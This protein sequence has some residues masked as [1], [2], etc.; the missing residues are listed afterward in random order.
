MDSARDGGIVE[1][2]TDHG[3]TWTSVFNSPYVYNFYGYQTTNVDTIGD[4]ELAFTNTDSTWRDI[5]LCFDISWMTTLPDT[6][7]FRFTFKSDSVD[8]GREGWMIDNIIA[9]Q[10]AIHTII[11]VKQSEYLKVYPNPTSNIVYIEAQKQQEFH[12]IEHMELI[13]AQGEVVA[14]WDNLP[15]KFWFDAG[16]YGN[17]VYLLKI[18]TNLRTETF[19]IVVKK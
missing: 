11:N 7:M 14:K 15:T 12:I 17:G 3:S 1:Y 4:G 5:W 19:S 18:K 16:K 6:L 13:N 8:H 10:T 9:H 2:T